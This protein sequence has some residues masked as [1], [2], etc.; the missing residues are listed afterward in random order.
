MKKIQNKFFR[1]KDL[2]S[3]WFV[4]TVI[5]WDH[6]VFIRSTPILESKTQPQ[7]H[8]ILENIVLL[9]DMG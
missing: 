8:K 2:T 7:Q 9:S 5:I 3:I 4:Y 1:D 6:F